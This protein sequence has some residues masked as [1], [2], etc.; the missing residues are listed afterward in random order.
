MSNVKFE[1]LAPAYAEIWNR[2]IYYG[3]QATIVIYL[4]HTLGFS[5]SKSYHLYG[6]YTALTLAFSILGG[7]LADRVFG[8]Y[9]SV[10]ISSI[11]M[12]IGNI[13]LCYENINAVYIGISFIA[14]AIGLFKPNNASLL[15]ETIE[16][17]S[18]SEKEKIFSIF[19]L[20]INIGSLVGPIFYGYFFDEHLFRSPHIIT[21]IGMLSAIFLL[22]RFCFLKKHCSGFRANIKIN[23]VFFGLILLIIAVIFSCLLI[24]YDKITHITLIALLFCNLYLIV[25]VL[26]KVSLNERKRLKLIVVPMLSSIIYFAFLLQIYTSITTYIN[27]YVN[28]NI[29]GLNIPTP[30]F[31]SLEPLFLIISV[32]LLASFSNIFYK[33]NIA[34]SVNKKILIGLFLS[35]ISFI[36]FSLSTLLLQNQLLNICLI[37]FANFI[38]AIAELCVIPSSISLVNSVSPNKYKSTIMGVFYSSLAVSG[39]LSGLIAKFSTITKIQGLHSY[40]FTFMLFSFLILISLVIIILISRVFIKTPAISHS[41]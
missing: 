23:T 6:T 38:L 5:A 24:M 13:A 29:F 27:I 41:T 37:L 30:W 7:M 20:F 19:Y 15:G 8:Y 39:Y 17:N 10:V 1:F 35:L 28:K 3:L 9:Y 4:I 11:L 2:I 34:F 12:V 14:V 33:R 32:P 21:S 36:F 40:T 25:K 22:N 16:R 26:T 31:S 18:I